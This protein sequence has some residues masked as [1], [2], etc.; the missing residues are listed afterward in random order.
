MNLKSLSLKLISKAQK[1][2]KN[3]Y[4]LI[5]F[6]LAGKSLIP[7]PSPLVLALIFFAS[8][9]VQVVFG[10]V[11]AQ[12]KP[13][14]NTNIFNFFFAVV[15][16]I[17]VWLFWFL[18][19]IAKLVFQIFGG[20]I[21]MFMSINPAAS[22]GVAIR[23]L[24]QY[25]VDFSNLLMIFS[26]IIMG[27]V[28]VTGIDLDGLSLG[29]IGDSTIVNRVSL[30]VDKNLTKFFTGIMVLAV[31]VNFSL[32]LTGGVISTL[33]NIGLAG[34]IITAKVEP[35]D[36]APDFSTESGYTIYVRDLG[37]KFFYGIADQFSSI[38]CFSNI[39]I[40]ISQ[41]KQDGGFEQTLVS[42]AYT[43]GFKMDKPQK[44]QNLNILE[45]VGTLFQDSKESIA[46]GNSSATNRL[47]VAAMRELLLF[48][49]YVFAIVFVLWKF[50]K[51]AIFRVAYL[52]LV[53]IFSGV[54][55][56]LM[57][58]PFKSAKRVF[59]Y[60]LT[61]LITFGTMF[62]VFIYAFYIAAYIAGQ[63]VA[64]GAI[65]ISKNRPVEPPV[66]DGNFL[67]GVYSYI[68][69]IIT[70]IVEAVLTQ[71]I[72]AIIALTILYLVG[73]YLDD[74]WKKH[75]EQMTR[76][77]IDNVKKVP[78]W[79]GA[80]VGGVIGAAGNVVGATATATGAASAVVGGIGNLANLGGL[81]KNRVG[82]AIKDAGDFG[83]RIQ[84]VTASFGEDIKNKGTKTENI[85]KESLNGKLIKTNAARSAYLRA[86]K[87]ADVGKGD[88]GTQKKNAADRL[89][90]IDP[91][92]DVEGLDKKF[93]GWK[94]Q[95]R[96]QARGV[97]LNNSKNTVLKNAVDAAK[98]DAVNELADER[99][100][101]DKAN[102]QKLKNFGSASVKDQA[103]YTAD[104]NKGKESR[105]ITDR[106]NE[107]VELK[108]QKI[109]YDGSKVGS[110]DRQEAADLMKAS[111]ERIDNYDK[112]L[113]EVK[114]MDVDYYKEQ[115]T[116]FGNESKIAK[117]R[118]ETKVFQTAIDGSDGDGGNP[119]LYNEYQNRFNDILGRKARNNSDEHKAVKS[120]KTAV[121]KN[122]QAQ[123][124]MGFVE[125]V[126]S[127]VKQKTSDFKDT[128]KNNGKSN[129]N[130]NA[131][132]NSKGD[133][134]FGKSYAGKDTSSAREEKSYKKNINKD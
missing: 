125:D 24:W 19:L 38:S 67:T 45:T 63:N 112:D 127:F 68:N 132:N 51:L 107:E 110:A 126:D 31:L 27:V 28:Y 77:A 15:F 57:V 34:A 92:Y 123:Q 101:V 116:K 30:G 96:A 97:I 122:A 40:P 55:F 26:I 78:G 58:S 2:V 84:N 74:V 18:A 76:A 90:A 7:R 20:I 11:F 89:K 33:H 105:I 131:K 70:Y 47:F 100:D 44:E 39:I 95:A 91:S 114:K 8:L 13:A 50:I 53:M 10:S 43:C 62:V 73:N 87:R 119:E 6:I 29:N 120:Y 94:D 64:G 72:F 37:Y 36:K 130:Y 103:Q 81:G 42:S 86:L 113:K 14:E 75:A 22:N 99:F 49:I 16:L 111:R 106:I 115:S 52:W 48:L 32:T 65:A 46:I 108:T 21:F 35:G 60:W 85:V 124:A 17:L 61:L 54:A 82:N 5:R 129:L 56:A 128:R 118:A 12:E 121:T 134:L 80:A 109:K 69:N 88:D 79:A 1:F 4:F 133:N 117:D 3:A 71:S 104:L 9:G 25:F 93:G 59:E 83:R 41:P 98:D 102:I 23:G 66:G